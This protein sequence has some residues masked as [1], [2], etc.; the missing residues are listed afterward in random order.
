MW[1][2]IWITLLHTTL[3]KYA[4]KVCVW[5]NTAQCT[6][7]RLHSVHF[8]KERKVNGYWLIPL[9]LS[10]SLFCW[11]VLSAGGYLPKLLL[12]YNDLQVGGGRSNQTLSLPKMIEHQSNLD[13][14][15]PAVICQ[16]ML[17]E[18]VNAFLSVF[19]G[20]GPP[21]RDVVEVLRR[22]LGKTVKWIKSA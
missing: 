1:I 13:F 7:C 8:V 12:S 22:F 18:T 11:V 6:Q 3:Y 16:K 14:K 2:P 19:P 5:T 15:M 4:H 17:L 20:T 10:C 9:L 21:Y